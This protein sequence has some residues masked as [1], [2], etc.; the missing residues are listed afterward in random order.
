MDPV[1][2]GAQADA[3]A[4]PRDVPASSSPAARF[5]ANR[6]APTI[7]A[8]VLAIASLPLAILSMMAAPG[9]GSGPPEAHLGFDDALIGSIGAVIAG[10]LVGGTLGGRLVR[11]RPLA[12]AFVALAAAWPAAIVGFA[13]L[14]WY[15]GRTMSVGRVCIDGCSTALDLHPGGTYA[16]AAIGQYIQSLGGGLLIV[17][18]SLPYWI[19][20]AIVALVVAK[21]SRPGRAR[22]VA[23]VAAV[24][25]HGGLNAWSIYASSWAW[26]VLVAGVIAWSALLSW[27][28]LVQPGPRAERST[29]RSADSQGAP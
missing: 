9:P 13:L 28:R 20:P 2:H 22:R 25:A 4:A 27:P 11:R 8:L 26:V 18:M 12:G 24:L 19:V 23:F 14:P 7:L 15:L 10:A 29:L 3:R 16:F 1:E 17:G 5:A 21:W 6:F